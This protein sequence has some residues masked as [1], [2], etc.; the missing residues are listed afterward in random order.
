MFFNP[1]FAYFVYRSNH[2][3]ESMPAY[4]IYPFL[5]FL[6]LSAFLVAQKSP[7][8]KDQ[9]YF[10]QHT[11][12]ADAKADQQLMKHLEGLNLKKGEKVADIGA[13]TLRWEGALSLFTEGVQFYAVDIDSS[14]CN[15][16]QANYVER[17]YS[18]VKGRRIS[19]SIQTSL[20][21]T[22]KTGLPDAQMDKVILF[23]TFHEFSHPEA[24]LRDIHRSL[25]SNGRL[26]ISELVPRHAK[27]LHPGCQHPMY[28][29]ENLKKL[30]QSCGFVFE[31][32]TMIVKDDKKNRTQLLYRFRKS[33][34]ENG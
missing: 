8:N 32:Q 3:D 2:V 24:M 28:S 26:Y 19:N 27:D 12:L 23:Q 22:K 4:R 16:Q 6:L 15:A 7:K 18:I 29:P 34:Q 21:G 1:Y 5:A 14:C 31:T 30:V 10:Y 33:A 11:S 9:C 25:N 20:G 17:Y 13:G